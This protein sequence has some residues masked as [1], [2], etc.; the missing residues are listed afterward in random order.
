MQ[1]R[2]TAGRGSG[3]HIESFE[4]AFGLGS[5]HE[6][7]WLPGSMLAMEPVGANVTAL[8]GR[9]G[10]TQIKRTRGARHTRET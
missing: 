9:A 2:A 1:Y 7:F 8:V 5:S 4:N 6:A 3:G 10:P